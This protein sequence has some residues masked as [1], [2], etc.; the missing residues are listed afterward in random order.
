MLDVLKIREARAGDVDALFTITRDA[1]AALVPAY[2]TPAQSAGWMNG[3]RPYTFLAGVATGRIHV[4][5]KDGVVIG[6][7]ETVPGEITRLF[8]NPVASGRGVGG[9]L[10][11]LGLR[12]AQHGSVGAIV[13]ESLRN[14]VAFYERHCFKA[15]ETGFSRHG[16][17]GTPA[18][19]IV[20][21][22]RDDRR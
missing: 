20:R 11:T 19:E 22:V 6:Y 9:R 16:L 5:T 14:A 3:C 4:A 13:V 21:M 12:F 18:I 17:E 10:L 7:V 15:V 1:F 2:Y 8:V